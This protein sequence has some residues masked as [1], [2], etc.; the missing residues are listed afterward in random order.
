MSTIKTKILSW[1]NLEYLKTQL[2][3]RRIFEE[4]VN[5]C[6]VNKVFKILIRI[7]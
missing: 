7:K 3:A 2:K 6:E 4:G 5:S 1:L